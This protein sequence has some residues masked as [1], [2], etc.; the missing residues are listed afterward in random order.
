MQLWFPLYDWYIHMY[1]IT[2]RKN[3]H[4]QISYEFAYMNILTFKPVNDPS[5]DI[6][7]HSMYASERLRHL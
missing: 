6:L 4:I 3:I 7:S 2:K 1:L 5:K